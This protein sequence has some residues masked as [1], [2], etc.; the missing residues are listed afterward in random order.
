MERWATKHSDT[1]NRRKEHS[2][3]RKTQMEESKGSRR[4]AQR[5]KH[6]QQNWDQG[7]RIESRNTPK[8]REIQNRRKER[9]NRKQKGKLRTTA[10]HN[11]RRTKARTPKQRYQFVTVELLR[12]FSLK[13]RL[14]RE[15]LHRD[16]TPLLSQS[17][18]PLAYRPLIQKEAR[19]ARRLINNTCFLRGLIIADHRAS[20]E[21]SPA[22]SRHLTTTMDRE[23]DNGKV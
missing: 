20:H 14:R 9:R 4:T 7:C 13:F 10:R 8:H 2:G 6:H 1:E 5:L 18:G 11:R 15:N 16:L 19:Y 3:E 22:L 17:Y 21:D 12:S 23:R